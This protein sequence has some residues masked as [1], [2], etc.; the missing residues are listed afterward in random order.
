MKKILLTMIIL[1]VPSFTMAALI[2]TSELKNMDCD[3]LAVEKANANR[4]LACSNSNAATKTISKWASL[5]SSAL[6]SFGGDS[7]VATKAGGFANKV[8]NQSEA[9]QK[10]AQLFA[11]AQAN[12]ENISIYQKSKKCN[13]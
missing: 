3:A 8:A 9:E 5:A 13:L 7:E 6:S 4:V 11:D 2:S 10:D 1:I 12:V